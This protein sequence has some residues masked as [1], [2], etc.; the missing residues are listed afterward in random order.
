[1]S[2]YRKLLLPG[3]ITLVV[4]VC[5]GGAII[6][7]R[8]NAENGDEDDAGP[9]LENEI[10]SV[11]YE[12]EIID[13][14]N[15][16]TD[17]R[18]ILMQ[19]GI[20][21]EVEQTYEVIKNAD[22]SVISKQLKSEQT[23]IEKQNRILRR[24]ALDR[25]ETIDDIKDALDTYFTAMKE[26]DYSG[27]YP[28]LTENDRMLYAS[29]VLTESAE[30][31]EF[32]VASYSFTQDL[33]FEYPDYLTTNDSALKP[34]QETA[35]EFNMADDRLQGLVAVQPVSVLFDSL[36]GRQEVSFD[37]RIKHENQQWNIE[38][39]GPTEVINVNK[40]QTRDDGGK[41]Y[42]K[43]LIAEVWLKEVIFFPHLN[44]V[45]IHYVLFNKSE[46]NLT[47][48][49]RDNEIIAPSLAKVVS[50]TLYDEPNTGYTQL[51]N[52]LYNQGSDTVTPDA[53]ADGRLVFSPPP[54]PDIN[55]I[56]VTTQVAIDDFMVKIEFGEIPMVRQNRQAEKTDDTADTPETDT[57]PM[58]D[59]PADA[60]EE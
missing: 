32:K 7:L 34:I 50:A 48:D 31:I 59:E 25:Q 8:I 58:P 37:L 38:Y 45:F 23:L 22:G 42:G 13:D 6:Y 5:L 14:Y 21:G 52:I 4:V 24:G 16:F 54:G 17:D 49:E 15:L 57:A 10:I 19:I 28:L 33:Y 56:Y 26:G 30:A 55:A 35:T 27:A 51:E 9:S 1:M 3:I 20:N 47:T 39:F 53:N 18:D 60:D 29:T 11:P 44:K 12:E 41:T 40:I 46:E 2:P 36:I 43:P